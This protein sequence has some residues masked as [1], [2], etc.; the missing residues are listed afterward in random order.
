M[1]QISRSHAEAANYAAEAEPGRASGIVPCHHLGQAAMSRS[2]PRDEGDVIRL[3]LHM[4]MC[5]KLTLCKPD[6]TQV[7]SATLTSAAVSPACLRS[8]SEPAACMPAMDPGHL[9]RPRA[10]S[11]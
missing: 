3:G 1:S 11:C 6:H 4:A 10:R 7:S 9:R 2:G 5:V 8:A